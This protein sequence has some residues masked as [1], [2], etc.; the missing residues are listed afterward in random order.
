MKPVY[1]FALFDLQNNWLASIWLK[2]STWLKLSGLNI[3]LPQVQN[4]HFQEPIFS[5]AHILD[6]GYQFHCQ[7]ITILIEFIF[8]PSFP[9]LCTFQ[10][11]ETQCVFCSKCFFAFH[12][13]HKVT[14][15]F[16]YFHIFFMSSVNSL[17]MHNVILGFCSLFFGQTLTQQNLLQACRYYAATLF[18]KSSNLSHQWT[19]SALRHTM[20]QTILSHIYHAVG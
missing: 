2:H 3:D 17:S 14:F 15:N 10:C 16:Q 12:L 9:H 4:W 7:F 8:M 6:L 20:M 13:F 5:R 19:Q 18:A 1:W 11:S